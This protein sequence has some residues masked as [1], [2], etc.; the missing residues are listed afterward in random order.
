MTLLSKPL[1]I[2]IFVCFSDQFFPQ[3]ILDPI[4]PLLREESRAFS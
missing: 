2:T 4:Y 3:P 1:N